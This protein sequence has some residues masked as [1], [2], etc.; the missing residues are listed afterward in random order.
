[1]AKK[2][3]KPDIAADTAPDRA[4]IEAQIERVRA[5][6]TAL[7]GMMQAYGR[8][9]LGGAQARAEALPQEALAELQ[10]QLVSLEDDL[11]AKLHE[12]PL[13]ALGLAALIG[14]VAGLILRR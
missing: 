12:K 8:A 7:G 4:E 3:A 9:R 5:D 11:K 13:Q 10:Q 1:M 14:L 6:L 2:S